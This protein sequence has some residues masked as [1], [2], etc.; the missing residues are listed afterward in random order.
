MVFFGFSF[1]TQ[2]MLVKSHS[3]NDLGEECVVPA[4]D[5][6]SIGTQGSE[7]QILKGTVNFLATNKLAVCCEINFP[8]FIKEPVN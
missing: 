7:L 8:V 2:H 3:I 4:L 6:L 5:I 1:D